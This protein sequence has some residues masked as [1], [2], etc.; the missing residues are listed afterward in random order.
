MATIE[1]TQVVTAEEV[2]SRLSAVLGP[3]FKVS[4][5]SD[6]TLKVGRTGVIPAKVHIHRE[7][8]TTRFSVSTT[9]LI[10]SRIIQLTSIN[11]KVR[12]ALKETFGATS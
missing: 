7:G 5:E 8:G 2:Q 1:T 6:S 3:S 4:V 12:R 9:G 11:P 10:V